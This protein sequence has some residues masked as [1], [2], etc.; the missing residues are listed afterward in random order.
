MSFLR[1]ARLNRI[2]EQGE[3]QRLCASCLKA[4]PRAD[5]TVKDGALICKDCMAPMSVPFATPKVL[6][7]RRRVQHGARPMQGIHHSLDGDEAYERAGVYLEYGLLIFRCAVY[8]LFFV[9]AQKSELA[10]HAFQGF[11]VADFGAWLVQGIFEFRRDPQAVVLEF[12]FF[13]VVLYFLQD[14]SGLLS[15]PPAPTDRAVVGLV[16]LFY[17]S[18]RVIFYVLRRRYEEGEAAGIG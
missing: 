3:L 1:V 2:R 7:T 16:F 18:T 4:V 6:G 15:L 12:C 5:L 9:A 10:R 8:L 11:L 17:F 13:G 14:K